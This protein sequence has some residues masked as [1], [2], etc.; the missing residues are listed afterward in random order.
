M[1]S[2]ESEWLEDASEDDESEL[3]KAKI[4]EKYRNS[5]IEDQKAPI[6]KGIPKLKITELTKFL[7]KH[8]NIFCSFPEAEQELIAC[9]FHRGLKSNSEAK[10]RKD[11]LSFMDAFKYHSKTEEG[12]KTIKTFK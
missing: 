1:P 9:I 4:V 2:L 10:L 7:T 5:Y 12:K 6:L 8:W 11:T 3:T